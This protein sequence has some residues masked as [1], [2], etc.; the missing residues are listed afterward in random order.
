MDSSGTKGHIKPKNVR[1]G[2]KDLD[3]GPSKAYF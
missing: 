3:L 2:F 1:F